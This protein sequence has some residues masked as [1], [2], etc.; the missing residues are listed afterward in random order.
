MK[1]WM[2]VFWSL[3]VGAQPVWG[4][5][6][7]AIEQTQ[8]ASVS[9]QAPVGVSVAAYD[10]ASIRMYPSSYKGNGHLQVGNG[11]MLAENLTLKQIVRFAYDLPERQLVGGPAWINEKT[12]D[13]KAKTDRAAAIDG[14][15]LSE[16]QRE[17]YE[18]QKLIPLQKLLEDRF[19]LKVTREDRVLPFYAIVAAKGG[20]KMKPSDESS[21]RKQ[22]PANSFRGGLGNGGIRTPGIRVAGQGKLVAIKVTLDELARFLTAMRFSGAPAVERPV[23]NKTGST[24]EYD[25]TLE[26]A[27]GGGAES[28]RFRSQSIYCDS[29]TARAEARAAEGPGPGHGDR[30]C[31]V[32][33]G[34]LRGCSAR[35]M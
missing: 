19:Q 12:F 14:A 35:L 33:D 4:Q 32:A 11:S 23:L 34:K 15:Q 5:Q 3:A 16:E 21:D 29:G 28:R 2:A 30:P 7:G 10:V 26:F 9:A 20:I 25:F 13:I 24:G 31:G 22:L 8:Q 18:S 17:T 6:S 27:P 1:K